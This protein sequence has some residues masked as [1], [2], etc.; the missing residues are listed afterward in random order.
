MLKRS[1][2]SRLE[3]DYSEYA[4]SRAKQRAWSSSNPGNVAIRAEL[5]DRAMA[6]VPAP[7]AAI[8]DIGCGAGWWLR[9]LVSRGVAPSRLVGLDALEARAD[10][11]RAALPQA[12]FDRGDARQLPYRDGEFGLVTMFTVLSS[13]G[14]AAEVEAAL[15]EAKRVLAPSGTL[16]VYEPRLPTPLNPRTRYISRRAFR[17]ILGPDVRAQSLTLV[18]PVA[19]RLGRAT[20][21]MYPIVVRL[22]AARSH[23]LVVWVK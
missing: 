8:L 22:P 2:L 14:T 23:R 12:R 11:A 4:Q 10:E 7:P 15:R 13:M 19:R 16:L 18:P 1:G 21:A 9:T 17:R 6:Y 3:Q 5:V 20:A